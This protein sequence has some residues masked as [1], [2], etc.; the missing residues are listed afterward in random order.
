MKTMKWLSLMC[1]LALALLAVRN[2]GA[3][4]M[5]EQAVVA[6]G[7]GHTAS[8]TMTMDLTIGQPVAGRAVGPTTTG[9]FGFWN[10]AF[11][12]SSVPFPAIAAGA[13]AD[14]VVTPNPVTDGGVV[15][16][17]L[18]A[19]TDVDVALYDAAGRQVRTLYSGTRSAGRFSM[20]LGPEGLA[21]GVYFVAVSVPG[22]LMQHPV[23]IAR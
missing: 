22:G 7:G 14:L 15:E 21:S 13:V 4:T 10:T 1:A 17:T 3:Q 12:V 2:A 20:P 11:S 23:T 16:V 18:A 5:M 19:G 9:Q 6:E 8:A